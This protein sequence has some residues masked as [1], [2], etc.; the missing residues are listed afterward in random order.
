MRLRDQFQKL[1]G[2]IERQSGQPGLPAL[3]EALNCSERNARLLLRKMEDKGWLRWEAG[4]G[5]GHFSRLSMLVSPQQVAL[6]HLSGLLAEGE[7]EEAFASLDGEQRKQLAARLPDFL[8]VQNEQDQCDRIRIPINRAV[9]ALDPP[10]IRTSLEAHLARQIFSRLVEFDH[11]SQRL[12]PALA[13]YWESEE[14]G[15]VWHFWLRPG[16]SFHDGSPLEPEDVRHTLLRLRDRPGH[17]QHLYASLD[18]IHVGNNR[19]VTCRLKARDYLWPH[20]L[21]SLTSSVIPRSR[22]SDF[23][24]MPI[25][26]GPFRIKRR[27]EYRI[28]LSAFEDYYR[29]RALLDE[30]DLW[31]IAPSGQ[32]SEF[33]IHFGRSSGSPETHNSI[34]EV[35]PG[36]TTV[37]CNPNRAF[38][39]EAWQRQ[40]LA[41]WLAPSLLV[42]KDDASRTAASG[43]MPTWKHRVARPGDRPPVPEH[44]TLKLVTLTSP[45]HLLL[46]QQ[47]TDRLK[48]AR[49]D[50]EVEALSATEFLQNDWL[51]DADLVV[52]TE[53]MDSDTDLGC[54]EWFASESAFR[55]WMPKARRRRL[56]LQLQTIRAT[57]EA[58]ARVRLLADIGKQLVDE[59][60]LIPIS[61]VIQNVHIASH[62]G[63]AKE[64]SLDLVPLADLWLR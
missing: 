49:I 33:D 34:A 12:V 32:T 62:V 58:D 7:L 37:T 25:G 16:L 64:V 2:F 46:V 20:Y 17:Y 36:C 52:S 48:T 30:I 35:Q 28:T 31:V 29:E 39:R 3:A 1:H 47:I 23:A 18:G 9:W 5:R 24:L 38:F 13:H 4:S 56:D 27:S 26:C 43:L 61:H 44:T 22:A 8:Q 63:G 55:R 42:A 51:N 6:D 59:A 10:D 11:V 21:A 57:A 14:D 15:T 40:T 54:Y 53:G 19:R 50:V 60:W 41:D 45:G